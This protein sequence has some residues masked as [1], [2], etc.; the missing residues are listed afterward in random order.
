[1]RRLGALTSFAMAAGLVGVLT[2]IAP[3]SAQFA[4]TPRGGAGCPGNPQALG[5]S[6]TLAI[7]PGAYHRLG[8][9]QYRETL[10][11]ADKE[12]VLTFD[13][14]PLPPYSNEVLDILAAQCVKVTYFLVGA[15][16]REFPGVV[17]RIYEEGHTIGT[18]SENH[19]LRF[20][21]LPIEKLRWQIDQGIADVSAALG[22]SSELAPFFRI[23][24]LERT[25]AIERELDAR[26]LVTFSADVVADDWFRRIRPAE[27]ARRA[28]SRLEA[29]GKGILLLHDIHRTTVAAL[30]LI[31][32]ELKEKGFRVVHVVPAEPNRIEI[33]SGEG[34]LVAAPTSGADARGA[35]LWPK[36][37][38]SVAGNLTALPAPDTEAFDVGYRPWRYATLEGAKD[39][40]GTTAAADDV[41]WCDLSNIAAPSAQAQLPVP[42][43]QDIGLPL[44]DFRSVAEAADLRPSLAATDTEESAAAAPS[45]V[46]PN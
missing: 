10:P 30:P 15:M 45:A 22:D 16:A 14:G 33:A 21:G 28:M 23:P 4:S 13:D 44:Q 6:R 2:G 19:P 7:E 32:R 18:H 26:S 40:A 36:V 11:L 29:H 17:R 41:V 9:M 34:A 43:M 35:A 1:M 8:V 24:G 3:A 37:A 42:S 25:D 5:T 38:A 20:S 46:S 12:V 27:I 31:L 39:R